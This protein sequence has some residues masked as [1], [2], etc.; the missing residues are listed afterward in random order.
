VEAAHA[1]RAHAQVFRARQHQRVTGD[2]VA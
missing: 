2:E 1:L